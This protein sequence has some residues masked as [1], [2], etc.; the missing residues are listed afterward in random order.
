MSTEL[1]AT[2]GNIDCRADRSVQRRLRPLIAMLVVALIAAALALAPHRANAAQRRV[3]MAQSTSAYKAWARAR[4]GARQ[5]AALDA[6][7]TH[8]SGWNARA[9][10]P[11]SGAYGIPQALPGRKMNTTGGDWSWNGYT[12]MRW[13]LHY[14]NAR[15][16][17]PVRAWAFWQA[18]HW[19]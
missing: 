16:G 17:S 7:W 1:S 18:H 10:N 9:Q 4:V 2:I 3:A 14:I 15:Y 6:I 11:S 5:F 12:Q 8:E 13:G 19:Y